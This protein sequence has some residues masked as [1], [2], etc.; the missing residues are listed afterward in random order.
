MATSQLEAK[1]AAAPAMNG[2]LELHRRYLAAVRTQERRAIAACERASRAEERAH[3]LTER[4]HQLEHALTSDEHTLVASPEESFVGFSDEVGLEPVEGPY[5][6]WGLPALRWGTGER[7]ALQVHVPE[8]C[9][10]MMVVRVRT[11]AP[12]QSVTIFA[13]GVERGCIELST[14]GL[15]AVQ[16]IELG[17]GPGEHAIEL[18][19]AQSHVE[20]GRSLAVMYTMLR[21]LTQP[22]RRRVKVIGL[23]AGIGRLAAAA[24]E[25]ADI[26][27]AG[28]GKAI[29]ECGAGRGWWAGAI[30][31]SLVRGADTARVVAIEPDE[32]A[33][34]ALAELTESEP[35]LRA[36]RAWLGDAIAET[37]QRATTLDT[38]IASGRAVA[39]A[40]IR[41]DVGAATLS[42]LEGAQSAIEHARALLVVAPPAEMH[43]ATLHL[44]ARGYVMADFTAMEPAENTGPATAEVLFVRTGADR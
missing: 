29:I 39:P 8:G 20:Q 42:V 38:L 10:A 31:R 23:P 2:D 14:P 35:N 18:R 9:T 43:A 34:A 22:A 17:I 11:N 5:P 1:P 44:H 24:I 3:A 16:R 12:D 27:S 28:K 40:L 30:A 41:F 32:A 33:F 7:T 15:F 36:D 21:V 6:Q 37:D 26:R 13:D 25:A 4:V 19:Y